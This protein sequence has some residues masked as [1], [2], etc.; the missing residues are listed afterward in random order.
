MIS[1]RSSIRKTRK[2]VC[3]GLKNYLK[4]EKN[5]IIT[6]NFKQICFLMNKCPQCLNDLSAHVKV[7]KHCGFSLLKDIKQTLSILGVDETKATKILSDK[8]MS[9]ESWQKVKG[10]F[11][12][13][14]RVSPKKRGQFLQNACGNDR[15]LQREMGELFSSYEAADGSFL[16]EPA[17]KELA[18]LILE[19][20]HPGKTR[21]DVLTEN[22]IAG[23]V[24]DNRYR[25]IGLLGKGGMG[26]VYLAQDAK[27]NRKVALKI[28][29][30]DF[31]NDGER[32]S[33][34]VR[35]AQ[36]AS[37]LNHPN[38]ITIYEISEF[39]RLN[40]IS[41]EYIEGETLTE[42]V[43]TKP[44]KISSVL[45]IAIQIASALDEAHKAGIIHR[46]I[47][48]DNIMVRK[49]GFV[50]ILDFGIAKL[51][52]PPASDD[53]YQPSAEAYV[54]DSS[55]IQ[56][57]TTPGMII[58]TP[59]YMSPEQARGKEVDA[60]TD[61][62]S[63]GVV[64]YEMIAGRTPFAGDVSLETFADLIDAEPP[65]MERFAENVPDKLNR[66]IAKTLRKKKD[67]RYQAMKNV[68][69]DLE[70]LRENLAF[71]EHLGKSYPPEAS[72]KT[73]FLQTA[74][75]ETNFQ[76]AHTQNSFSQKTGRHQSAMLAVLAT[77]IAALAIG[78][79]FAFFAPHPPITSIAVLPFVNGNNDANLDYL[80]DGLSESVIDR[81]SQ[82]PQLKVIASSSSF[83]Y[84]GENI[85][86]QEAA[87][88][89]GVQAIVRGVFTQRGDNLIVRVELVDT[90]ENVQLWGEQFNRKTADALAVQQEIAQT[91]AV[92]LRL[93]LSG[94]QRE[95][96]AK[97]GTDNLQAYELLL[98]GDSVWAV[99]GKNKREAY[100]KAMESYKQAIVLD[101]NYALAYARLSKIYRYYAGDSLLDPKDMLP[102]ARAAAQKA[103]E[104]DPNLPNAHLQLAELATQNWDWQTA[105]REFQRTLELNPNMVEAHF[106]YAHYLFNM[107]RNEQ[108]V[109]EA[110]RVRELDPGKLSSYARLIII[111]VGVGRYDEAIIKIKKVH[112]ISP[113]FLLNNLGKSY[114]GKGMYR[115]AIDAFQ[116][117]ERLVGNLP[118]YD[119]IYLGMAYARAGERE[120]AQAILEELEKSK[121]YISPGELPILYVALGERDKAFAVLEK[122]Y[123][124]HDLQLQHL[125][126]ELGFDPLR[127]DPRFHDLLR[128]VG[129][130]Q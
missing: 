85:D 59:D 117:K 32:M 50:K 88:E 25:I 38:I 39:E 57:D 83:K 66:I 20:E 128:R 106:G 129:L 45:D 22:F 71:D 103:V 4:S 42:Y 63:F 127:D 30:A 78:G 67:E 100:A 5:I 68:L 123:A 120:K 46:D 7:C 11:K 9:P 79:Y 58:G 40:F 14:E 115:E 41:T 12:A 77:I 102:K 101:P 24:L 113:R 33:R 84:R 90:R 53:E 60:R 114:L 124:A 87:N 97:N 94:A 3:A 81:L 112:D 107:G 111:L 35:E 55:E 37:A 86:L 16:E 122:A 44:L 76:T 80:S 91:I 28:L 47:K 108:A 6:N 110:Y 29:P 93:K 72:N 98:Q 8:K 54:S 70:G 17:A 61:I 62:F 74:T 52:E 119:K 15:A 73:K 104:L 82:L 99:R 51:S 36:S 18:S 125:N 19:Q 13:A 121:E 10:L 49:S 116:Q 75:G 64:L 31:A 89:L 109:A 48:P 95:Q 118:S 69:A 2:A 34:F 43:K 92:K 21:S 105:E 130:P 65:Q 96:L 27:L 56:T 23:T 1:G 26:E 126:S